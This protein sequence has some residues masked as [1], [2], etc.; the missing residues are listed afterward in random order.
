MLQDNA[1][2][3][4]VAIGPNF[5]YTV[6]LPCTLWFL[7]KG[8]KKTN[9]K[10]IIW[11]YYELVRLDINKMDSGSAIPSTSRDAFYAVAVTLP[12]TEVVNAF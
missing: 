8:K 9:R 12:P 1:V 3:V 6:T 10:D 5:F 11:C 7:N 2:D 4:M